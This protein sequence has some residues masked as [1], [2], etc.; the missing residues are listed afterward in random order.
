VN[1]HKLPKPV[2]GAMMIFLLVIACVGPASLF[3][4]SEGGQ[5]LYHRY[6]LDDRP[7]GV[8]CDELPSPAEARRALDD[9]RDLVDE[10]EATGDVDVAVDHSLVGGKCDESKHAEIVVTHHSD[11]ERTKIEKILADDD[12]GDVPVS[13]HKG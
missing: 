10:I 5:L 2:V 3:L 12:F 7:S 6:V 13:L 9:H 1:V 11:A 4:A 8:S